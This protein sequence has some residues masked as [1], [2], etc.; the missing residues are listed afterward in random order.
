M[1]VRVALFC[2]DSAHESCARALVERIAG[3]LGVAVSIR[4]AT[5]SSG[6]GRLK[7]ELKAFQ[8]VVS[9]SAGTPD[10]LVV[11]IDAN[12]VGPAVRRAEIEAVLDAAVF[13]VV[14]IGTPN[15]CVERWLLADPVSF[16]A[17]F[18]TQPE[19]GTSQTRH[20][21]KDRLVKALEAGGEIV[22][23]GGAEFAEEIIRPMVLYRAGQADSTIRKFTSDLRAALQRLR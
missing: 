16:A 19:V 21:W 2:E 14:V 12:A 18:G 7:H 22:V 17:T 4:T 10:L 5:A 11:L 20:A 23:Q 13:P 6:I 15:P 9:R 3:E 8:S 1:A